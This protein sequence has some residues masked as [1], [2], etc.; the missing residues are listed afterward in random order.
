M[1][2]LNAA[3]LL[4]GLAA[5]VPVVIHLLNRRRRRTVD[6]G[7]MFLIEQVV[8]DDRRRV[9]LKQWLLLA[10]RCI[11]VLLLAFALARPALTAARAAAADASTAAVVIVD[12]SYSMAAP[13]AAGESAYAAALAAV[14]RVIDALPPG[15]D[16]RVMTPAGGDPPSEPTAT[17]ADWPAALAAAVA[18]LEDAKA[19]NK[20]VV[21][22]SDMRGFDHKGLKPSQAGDVQA[23]AVHLDTTIADAPNLAVL[24]LVQRPPVASPGRPVSYFITVRNTG[25]APAPAARVALEVDGVVRDARGLS[26]NAG[27][28]SVVRLKVAFAEPGSHEVAAVGEAAGDLLPGD[29]RYA[30]TV[31][32]GDAYAVDV[33]DDLLALA[34]NPTGDAAPFDTAAGREPD[35]VVSAELP[36]EAAAHTLIFAHNVLPDHDDLPAVVAGVNETSTTFAPGPYVHPALS[37]WNDAPGDLSAVAVRRRLDLEA[38]PDAEVILRFADGRPAVVSNGRVHGRRPARR[39][40]L[41]RPPAP[42]RV[43]APRAATRLRPTPRG[44]RG[45]RRTCRRSRSRNCPNRTPKALTPTS[46]PSPQPSGSGGSAGKSGGRR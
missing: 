33:R 27:A 45:P 9:Q 28:E 35:L 15:S 7:A 34:L 32:V 20:Q 8:R 25:V 38:K 42:G 6:W 43:R 26:L 19:V 41:E 17:G 18:H 46:P 37:P 21:L 31:R 2:F 36:S 4:G 22:L 12:D 1:T 16:V 39:R 40:F 5:A 24:S 13:T 29:D 10:L 14:P 3:M 30:A 11:A 23:A 44:R